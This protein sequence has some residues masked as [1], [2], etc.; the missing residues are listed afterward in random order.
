VKWKLALLAI[1]GLFV[2]FVA[3]VF[4]YYSFVFAREVKGEIVAI[5][6]VTQPAAIIGGQALRPADLYSFAIAIREEKG[7]IVTASTEDRQW[8]VAQKGQCAE[9]KFFPYPFWHLDKSGTY[10]GARLLK[11]YECNQKPEV[12]K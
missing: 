4:H 2:A 10:F 9:A 12:S 6:R 11:L 7:E 5:E 3:L 1:F 8:A